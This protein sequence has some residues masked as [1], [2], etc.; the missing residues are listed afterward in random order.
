MKEELLD[1][2][3]GEY[4]LRAEPFH[5]DWA[6]K[7]TMGYLGNHLLNAS[8]N[9]ASERKFNIEHLIDYSW[10]LSRLVVE[11]DQMPMQNEQF[12]V[13]T[14]V[15]NVQRLFTSRNYTIIDETGQAIGHGRSIWALINLETRKPQDLVHFNDGQ[16]APYLFPEKT[17]PIDGPGR[18]KLSK[19]APCVYTHTASYS[20]IDLNGH[21]NSIRYI[22][23]LLNTFE[24]DFHKKYVLKRFEIAYSA[25]CYAGDTISI[26]REEVAPQQ[27]NLEVRRPDGAV[28]VKAQ[29]TFIENAAAKG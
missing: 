15:E 2:R 8:G 29:L 1:S 25:E 20:D 16:L 24:M 10:V 17:S 27:Y 3:V 28:A 11:I 12:S 6:G 4:V 23:H 14:W 7:L 5:C 21:L 13:Q 19:D 22:E 9:H 18:V 26:Y